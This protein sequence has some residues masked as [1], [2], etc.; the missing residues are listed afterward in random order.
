VKECDEKMMQSLLDEPSVAEQAK[1]MTPQELALY[2]KMLVTS[3]VYAQ[4]VTEQERKEFEQ[5]KRDL[6]QSVDG[7]V[8]SAKRIFGR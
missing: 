7:L 4:Y 1:K 3:G 8:Q 2:K 5:N 6:R